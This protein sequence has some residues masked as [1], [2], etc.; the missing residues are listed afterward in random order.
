MFAEF[1]LVYNNQYHKA[2]PTTDKLEYAKRLWYPYLKDY[3]AQQI[4]NACHRAIRE[5]EFLPTVK[6]VLKYI[7]TELAEHGLPE[8]RQAYIEACN[9]PN[10]KAT[11]AW[12]HPAVYYA[13]QQSDWFFLASNP[14]HI[15]FPVFDRAYRQLCDEVLKG[16]P[17][18]M[19]KQDA[20]PETPSQPMS[21]QEGLEALSKLREETGF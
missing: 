10:P 13:G 14:E 6:G 18:S 20:L 2:F 17:L 9:A 8:S 15:A 5:S 12:S 21:K 3:S 4:L 19:P 7:G 11:Y 1:Q 16:K